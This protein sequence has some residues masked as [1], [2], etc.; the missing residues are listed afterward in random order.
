MNILG[1]D[2]A[3]S[4]LT[5]ALRVDGETVEQKVFRQTRNHDSLLTPTVRDLLTSRGLQVRDLD[6]V[7]ISIGPGSFT[8]LRIGLS[9]VK[10]LVFGLDVKVVAVPTLEALA[11]AV[12]NERRASL[13]FECAIVLPGRRGE[14]F[15]GKFK[16]SDNGVE[17]VQK[18]ELVPVQDLASQ[19]PE[20]F[21][22][23]GEGASELDNA[24]RNYFTLYSIEASAAVVAELGEARARNGEYE[25][26]ASL[27]PFYGKEFLV[28][29]AGGRLPKVL[30]DASSQ[31][32]SKD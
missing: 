19:L 24:R 15:W 13:P 25:D 20:T 29:D 27:E 14:V 32:E 17:Q 26:I 2:T 11:C 7:A 31:L 3:T 6:T 8:G 16:L 23:A 28:K 10:G 1:I 30:R 4:I 21:V 18:T 12:R 22:I 5:I 9:F